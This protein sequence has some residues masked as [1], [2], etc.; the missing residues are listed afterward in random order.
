LG[1]G[2]ANAVNLFN[3]E[4]VIIGAGI[5]RAGDLFLETVKRTVKARDL[6]TAS[7]SVDIKISELGDT[8][9]AQGAAVLILKDIFSSYVSLRI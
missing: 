6:H 8:A 1:I 5:S 2:I 4:L 7:T 9:A 3:P